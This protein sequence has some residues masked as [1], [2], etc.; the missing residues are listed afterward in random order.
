L[1]L[2]DEGNLVSERLKREHIVVIPS[3]L[4][5]AEEMQDLQFLIY[6][7][8]PDDYGDCLTAAK[9]R[10]HLQAFPEGQFVALDT[11]TGRIVGITASLRM[12]FDPERPFL[13]SWATTTGDG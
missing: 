3:A 7:A 9:F 2:N 10:Q 1:I 13:E 12:R 6:D 4:D 8:T 11:E 5:Y